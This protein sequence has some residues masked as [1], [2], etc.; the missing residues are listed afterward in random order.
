MFLEQCSACELCAGAMQNCMSNKKHTI[1]LLAILKFVNKYQ[2]IVCKYLIAKMIR[3]NALEFHQ[4]AAALA[5]PA[6]R[7]H[8]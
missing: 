7:C 3:I 5:L 1:I 8:L 2:L 6:M 4:P